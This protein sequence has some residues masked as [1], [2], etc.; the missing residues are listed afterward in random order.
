MP[1][2]SVDCPF[3][4]SRV[5]IR[6]DGTGVCPGCQLVVDS[7][8][9]P[10]GDKPKPQIK[11]KPQAKA[12]PPILAEQVD[13]NNERPRRKKCPHCAEMVLAEARVCKHCGRDFPRGGLHATIIGGPTGTALSVIVWLAFIFI[14]LPVAVI[15]IFWVIDVLFLR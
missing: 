1:S 2:P 8:G 7:Q 11:E 9:Q 6:D 12:S 14:A 15:A 3:C 10:V 4:N 13:D 5:P